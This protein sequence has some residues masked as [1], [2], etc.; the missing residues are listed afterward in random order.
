MAVTPHEASRKEKQRRTLQA[1]GKAAGAADGVNELQINAA[2]RKRWPKRDKLPMPSVD[3][4]LGHALKDCFM[5]IRMNTQCVGRN[6]DHQTQ[7]EDWNLLT[8]TKSLQYII[9]I[10]SI[11]LKP[12]GD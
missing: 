1:N 4:F 3:V 7:G 2:R 12:G 11:T 9:D 10:I 5:K 6:K 8:Q